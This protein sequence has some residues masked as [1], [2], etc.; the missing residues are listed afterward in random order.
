MMRIFVLEDRE[1]IINILQKFL[2]N[3]AKE[4]GECK[5]DYC[6][7]IEEANTAIKKCRESGESFNCYIFDLALDASSLEDN[8][9]SETQQ[10][11]FTGWIWI[12]NNV[13]SEDENRIN[14]C[15]IFSAYCDSFND[16]YRKHEDKRLI[17]RMLVLNKSDLSWR[18]KL[19]KKLKSLRG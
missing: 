1:D 3:F 10:G 13:L 4:Y 9:K 14:K 19:E 17:D 5:V 7:D 2:N 16:A 12:K 6:L 11:Y 8:L 18:V 15:V